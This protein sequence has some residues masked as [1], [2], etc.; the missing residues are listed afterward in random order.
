MQIRKA[1][2][3]LFVI[4]A[5]L[6]LGAC[7]S[8]PMA[9]PEQDAQAKKMVPPPGKSLIYVYR[10]ETMGAAIKMAVSLDGRNAGQT[11]PKTYFMWTVSPGQHEIASLTENTS[12][13]TVNT[14]SGK[15]YYVWQEVKMGAWSAGSK[16]QRVDDAKG[17]A[18]VEECK[19]IQGEF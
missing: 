5:A 1:L 7:A 8:V 3:S 18:G 14:D 4:T 11:G 15:A 17:R 9:T 12:K 2:A 13:L 10:N 19:L 16:L 6:A